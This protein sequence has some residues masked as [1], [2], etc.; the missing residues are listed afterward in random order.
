MKTP[1]KYISLTLLVAVFLTNC[2][3]SENITLDENLPNFSKVNNNLFRGGQPTR[4]GVRSLKARFGIKTVIL[5]RTSGEEIEKEDEWAKEA[6]LNFVSL[7][8][9]NWFAP[10]RHQME[11]AMKAITDPK[12]HPVFVHCK[13]GADRT[14]TV[15]AVYRMTQEGWTPERASEE[16]KRF[17]IGWW[18]VWM[19]DYIEDYHKD[20]IEKKDE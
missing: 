16:A 12:N 14:G 20:Y 5:F 11:A 7:P 3:K 17:G 19:K 8:L 18:Q 1:T 2:S 13:R 10:K 4:E 9:H 6:G 15:I